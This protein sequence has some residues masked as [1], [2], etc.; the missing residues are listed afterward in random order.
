MSSSD[1]LI[2]LPQQ[3]LRSLRAEGKTPATIA[4]P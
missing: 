4:Y 1:Y 2:S 3:Y